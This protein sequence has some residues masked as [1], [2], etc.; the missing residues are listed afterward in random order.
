MGRRVYDPAPKSILDNREETRM[1][2]AMT[3]LSRK[4][5]VPTL[6]SGARV[7]SRN[8]AALYNVAKSTLISR[9][10][11]IL[12]GLPSAKPGAPT[13]LSAVDRLSVA[14]DGVFGDVLKM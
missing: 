12:S 3:V 7:N 9:L 11:K 8:V 5:D 2:Q 14:E 1:S 10:A 13:A 6:P 4:A